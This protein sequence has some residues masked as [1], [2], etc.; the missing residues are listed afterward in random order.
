MR[1]V[2]VHIH[3]PKTGGSTVVDVLSRNFGTGLLTTNSILN[4]YQYNA[5]QV[6]RIIDD[7]PHLKCLTGHKLSLDLPF[8]RED[9][10]LQA[11]TWIRDPVDRFVSHYFYHRNHTVLVPEAKRMDLLEYVEW[12]LKRENKEMYINGQTKF[13]SRGS[14][15]TIQS[16]VDEGKLL[17][18]PLSKLQ[19]SLYTLGQRFPD[20]FKNVNFR[21]KNVSKKDQALPDNFRE[22]ILPYVEKDMCLLEMAKQT[23]LNNEKVGGREPIFSAVHNATR[24]I[25][26]KTADLLHCVANCLERLTNRFT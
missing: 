18:F 8:Y 16:R 17:L 1:Q 7:N 25:A 23:C 9:L 4:D 14:P 12:A 13:L 21:N 15:E 22:L 10:D 19:E 3:I 24:K 20:L 11:F 26:F 2:F 6:A 5:V